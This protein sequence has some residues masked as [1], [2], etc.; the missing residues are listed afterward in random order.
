MYVVACKDGNELFIEVL[1]LGARL[2]CTKYAYKVL[3][4]AK[5]AQNIVLIGKNIQAPAH[6]HKT[7]HQCAMPSRRPCTQQFAIL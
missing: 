6:K 3:F 4:S 7:R 1:L 2:Y 5:N